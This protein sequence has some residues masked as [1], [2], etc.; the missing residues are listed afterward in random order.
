MD[1]RKYWTACR[2]HD[3]HYEMSEDPE[4]YR[5]GKEGQDHLVALAD[6]DPELN[7]IYL[8]WQDYH[9]N[10]GPRPAEPKLD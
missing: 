1:A 4:V 3:W 5:N 6:S 8:Q 10:S 7:E 2:I 9:F